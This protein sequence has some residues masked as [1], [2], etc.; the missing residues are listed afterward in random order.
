MTIDILRSVVSGKRIF[1]LSGAI[2]PIHVPVLLP[3]ETGVL[4][5]NSHTVHTRVT[6]PR[7][8]CGDAPH[9]LESI[10][11]MFFLFIFYYIYIYFLR[12]Y[13]SKCSSITQY[14]TI[15]H[16]IDR[17]QFSDCSWN[18]F[19]RVFNNWCIFQVLNIIVGFLLCTQKMIIRCFY[20][21]I[22][23]D[24]RRIGYYNNVCVWP[25]RTH[26]VQNKLIKSVFKQ[27]K[28]AYGMKRKT[29]YQINN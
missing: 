12:M 1:I 25:Y 7:G 28:A 29:R 8:G 15:D 16:R 13:L 5:N 21:F 20:L 22:Y 2:L 11:S 9:L 3:W 27:I 26:K 19:W 6:D 14:L 10:L 18:R 23:C 24:Q 4:V 17:P